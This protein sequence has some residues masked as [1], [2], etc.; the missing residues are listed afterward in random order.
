MPVNGS[1]D[2]PL[3]AFCGKYRILEARCNE[4]RNWQQIVQ[5]IN[6]QLSL[7]KSMRLSVALHYQ[8]NRA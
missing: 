1:Q 2:V 5:R 4:E 8:M 6:S 3:Q 7:K